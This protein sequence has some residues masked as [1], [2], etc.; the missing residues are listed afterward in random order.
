MKTI[1]FIAKEIADRPYGFLGIWIGTLWIFQYATSFSLFSH[2]LTNNALNIFEKLSFFLD[3]ITNLFR[4][5]SDPRAAS[6]IVF[7]FIAAINFFLMVRAYRNKQ[8]I[9]NKRAGTASTLGALIG[10]HCVACGGSLLAPLVT[11]IA[12]SGA[13]FSSSR[14]QTGIFISVFINA[15]AI[16]FITKATIK[17]A[18]KH[19]IMN[20]IAQQV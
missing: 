19:M 1:Q 9:K 15:I 2:I 18:K 20:E 10:T 5:S 8:A 14:I 11:T 13:Y 12:G 3:S 7:S 6:I 4:Y 17:M 16:V